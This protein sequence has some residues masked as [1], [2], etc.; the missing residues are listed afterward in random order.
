MKPILQKPIPVYL[1]VSLIVNV[2]TYNGTR[3]ITRGMHHY[4]MTTALDRSIPLIPATITVYLGCYLFWA[5]N[6]ALGCRQETRE[7]EHFL[8]AECFAKLICCACFLL[9]PTTNIRPEIIGTG[10]FENAMRWLYRTDAADNLFPSI[11]CLTSWFCVIAV[12]KQVTVPKWYKALSVVMAFAVCIST[13]TTR[14]HVLADVIAGVLLAEGSYWFV[15][16]SGWLTW[17]QGLLRHFSR[18]AEKEDAA[19]G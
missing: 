16:K 11:H 8:C 2:L 3:L 14:Q 5:I 7:A 12:R 15:R 18:T 6:Y 17:Y 4:D 1:A 19:H 10:F 9:L 13:L